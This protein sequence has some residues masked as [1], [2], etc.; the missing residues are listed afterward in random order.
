[1]GKG[2][3]AIR[4]GNVL[5]I[6]CQGESHCAGRI[7]VP[8]RPPIGDGP[9]PAPTKEGLVWQR[10]SGETIDDITLSPSVDAGDCGHF[11]VQNGSVV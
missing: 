10:V 6:E 8:F 4:G 7:R 1:M 5:L 9:E 11:N 3:V 2:L